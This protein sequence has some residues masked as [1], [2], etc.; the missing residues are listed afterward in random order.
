[1]RKPSAAEPSQIHPLSKRLKVAGQSRSLLSVAAL[2]VIM[3]LP[4]AASAAGPNI[5]RT[6]AMINLSDDDDQF[7]QQIDAF[8]TE[9]TNIRAEYACSVWSP[10]PATQTVGSTFLQYQGCSQDQTR[11]V[12]QRQQNVKTES[13]RDVGDLQTE[14][15]T[16]GSDHTRDAIGTLETWI[17]TSPTYT[18]WESVSGNYNCASWKPDPSSYKASASFTQTSS[19]C[20]V[21]QARERQA[22]EQET[23]TGDIRNSGSPVPESRQLSGQT[24]SRPYVVSLGDWNNQGAVSACSNWAP[25]TTTVGL[26]KAFTQTATDCKQDQVRTR[27]EEY[28]DHL[29]SQKVVALDGTEKQTI[30]ASDTRD[31]VGTLEDWMAASSTYTDWTT[32]KGPYSCSNWTPAGSSYTSSANFTQSSSTC[33]LDQIRNRQ[34]REQESNTG[35]YRNK[36]AVVAENQT[37]TKQS[38]T[39]PYQVILGA[40]TDSGAVTSCSN[41]SPAPSTVAVGSTYTQTATDCSQAQTRTRVEKYTD[42]ESGQVVTAVNGSE[43]RSITASSTRSATGTLETWVAAASTYTA[44]TNS[45]AVTSCSNWSPA[46]STVAVGQTFTQTAT[47][48][49]QAQTRTRQDREQETTTKAYRNKGAAVTET[50]S[51]AATSTRSAAGTLETWVAAASTYTAWTNSGAV[52]SCSNWSPDPSTVTVGQAFTQTATNCSQAQ[53]RTRQD[54]EQETT[55][56]AYRNK[57]SAVTETQTITASSTRSATGTKETWVA[58]ASAYGAWNN[59]SALY[60]CSNWS[61]AG[62]AYSYSVNFTQAAT[63]CSVNQT[64]SVQARQ[65]ETTTGA[66]R[67]VGAATTES[68]TIGNQYATR[69]YSVIIGAWQ[70]NGGVANCSG[71]T[72]DPST[73]ASG[74]AYTQTGS[75]TQAQIRSRVEQYNDHA[76]GALTTAVNTT[77][78][79]TVGATGYNTAYGTKVVQVCQYAAN[80]YDFLYGS[81]RAPGP[82]LPPILSYTVYWGGAVVASGSARAPQPTSVTVGGYTYTRS[83]A[84]DSSHAYICRQ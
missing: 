80:S 59:S 64:R 82:V 44:W 33:S 32:T 49:Q 45:G 66:L 55:T 43:S 25:A 50:Q 78:S 23:T 35:T 22:R 28:T 83:T 14:N 76:T 47:D 39:R 18:D 58:V 15:R 30:T 46:P 54:R 63:N 21:D 27:H 65:Q 75:C 57:G 71:W 62:S 67:N 36:G 12:Q 70:N 3:L 26:G 8:A 84:V 53:T 73:V 79:Q 19:T 11:T 9:W 5:I 1:M 60:S 37:L 16:V 10:D 42:N 81:Y 68:Q 61:P 6:P 51:I 31:S 38:A 13:I 29:T 4:A 7:W 74:T 72:P 69:P 34:D 17:A 77:E 20:V 24:A 41:W 56:K 2:A 52:T 40:W 48:C